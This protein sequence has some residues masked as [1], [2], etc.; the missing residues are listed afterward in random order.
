M[1]KSILNK[2]AIYFCKSKFIGK[3]E[4]IENQIELCRQ[5]IYIHFADI[6]D[7]DILIYEDE[8]FSGGNTERSQF[9]KMMKDAR[10]NNFS[11]IVCY[12]L[13]R[14]S[15]NI[16]DFAKL[17]EELNVLHISFV[18]IKEQFDTSSPLG[19]VMMYI[20]SVFSQL[21]WETIVE[22]IWDNM[23]EFVKIGCW[24]GGIIPMGYSSEVVE[25]VMVDGKVRR[26]YK[27]KLIDE[28]A[29]LVHL[30]YD[31]FFETNSFTKTETYLVQNNYRTKNGKLFN[32]FT[33]KN[34][35]E[36][37]VYMI[38]DVDAYRYF[39][40]QEIDLFAE[41]SEFDGKYGIMAYNKTIQ[42]RGKA[43][44]IRDMSEWIVV[45]GKHMGMIN[46]ADWIH[47]QQFLDQNKS[48]SYHKLKSNTALLS[49]LLFCGNCGKYMRSKLS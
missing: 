39:M 18:S 5:Y 24:L 8:G 12:R 34:F 33:I 13:D 46:G 4:S 17:I 48:K 36:N 21:E 11:T 49:G 22:C 15:R 35:L 42:K 7:E 29:K 14:I 28:E 47:T 31:K 37:P 45:V 19:R 16:G 23:Q 43:N 1:G 3:G 27:L 25:K 30:I 40:E 20:V 38:A 44:Q 26:A 2:I 6:K 10:D 41:E 9:K 32:R